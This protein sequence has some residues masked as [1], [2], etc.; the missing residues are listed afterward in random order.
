VPSNP[1]R[2]LGLKPAS[3]VG[4]LLTCWGDALGPSAGRLPGPSLLD[5]TARGHDRRLLLDGPPPSAPGSMTWPPSRASAL[6]APSPRSWCWATALPY[7]DASGARSRAAFPAATVHRVTGLRDACEERRPGA[8]VRHSA[9]SSSSC[10]AGGLSTRVKTALVNSTRRPSRP[11]AIPARNPPASDAPV[12]ITFQW[13]HPF[14]R[15]ACTSADGV[16]PRGPQRTWL[17]HPVQRPHH[18]SPAWATGCARPP[19]CSRRFFI[20]VQAIADDRTSGPTRL[21]EGVCLLMMIA[22]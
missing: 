15:P 13:R 22:S 18:A 4:R 17:R 16:V 12:R 21:Q 19:Q 11:S 9:L 6:P 7:N 1:L 10:A 2:W 14:I 5:G 3:G 8:A 20:S